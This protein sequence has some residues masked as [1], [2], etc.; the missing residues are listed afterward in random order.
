MLDRLTDTDRELLALRYSAGLSSAEM[1]D[2]LGMSAGAARVR[3]T[4]LLMR[5][6]DD[7]AQERGR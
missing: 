6:A 7:A 1:G 2:A 5:L 3:L 4:R